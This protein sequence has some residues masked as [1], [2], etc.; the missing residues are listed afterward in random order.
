MSVF[1]SVSRLNGRFTPKAMRLTLTGFSGLITGM[2][3]DSEKPD[4]R[5]VSQADPSGVS[6]STSRKR[7][8][9][10]CGYTSDD[11]FAVHVFFSARA[12][13][14]ADESYIAP[15]LDGKSISNAP[16]AQSWREASASAQGTS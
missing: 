5:L 13:L 14:E 4:G 8:W 7:R 9:I 1:K 11:A 2:P 15:M 3:S 12:L 10:R 16:T 6:C